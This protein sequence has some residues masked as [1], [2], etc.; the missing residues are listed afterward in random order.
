[1]QNIN[2]A[3]L[4]HIV[5]ATQNPPHFAF[6]AA[7]EA[8][9]AELVS[10]GLVETNDAVPNK[11]EGQTAARATNAGLTY[12]PQQSQDNTQ[13][14]GGF[15]NASATQ[16]NSQASQGFGGFQPQATQ[17][18]QGNGSI[19]TGAPSAAFVTISGFTP[20]TATAKGDK[21]KR[22]QPE[23]YPFGEL[24][25]PTQN[26]DGSMNY[27]GA[28]IF[29]PSNDYP[30]GAKDKKTGAPLTGKRTPE[31]MAFSLQSAVSAA[32]R[33]YN[34]VTSTKVNAKGKEVKTYAR[35]IEFKAVPYTFNG[36]PGA[37]IFRAK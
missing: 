13:G 19:A 6:I 14:F 23:K 15:G 29:V 8:G 17:T 5:T 34:T 28:S 22:E 35:D 26:P 21:P 4:A 25:A 27:E 32:N 37:V 16:D 2:A 12:Q 36:E 9:L 24:K 33:R 20:P 31:D 7:N 1:M 11:P 10:A 3:L 30:A 18:T